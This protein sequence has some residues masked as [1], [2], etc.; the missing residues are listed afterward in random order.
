MNSFIGVV[1]AVILLLPNVCVSQETVA[2]RMTSAILSPAASAAETSAGSGFIGG[3]QGAAEAELLP[4]CAVIPAPPAMLQTKSKYRADS[5]SKSSIDDDA[6]AT[7]DKTVQPIRDSVR[8]LTNIAYADASG[9]LVSRMQAECVLRNVDRWA[10]ANALTDMRSVDAYLSRDRWVAE[11]A[12]AVQSARMRVGLSKGRMA[13]YSIWF[14]SLARD[15]VEAYSLG[16]GPKAKTNN[17][18]Y[19]AGLSVAAIGFLLDEPNLK[20]WGKRSFDIGACQVDNRGFLPAELARGD[21]ALDYHVY[22]LRPLAAIAKLATDNG[23]PLQSKCFEGFDHLVTMTRDAMRD[24]TEFERVAG[25][26]QSSTSSETEY[27]SAL[28]LDTLLHCCGI[29]KE[30]LR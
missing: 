27:S 25:V 7:R 22:A 30:T 6:L 20:A 4:H 10:A 16:V 1:V 11:I 5:K 21:R 19:W 12:L 14:G 3:A 15:T 26:R 23:E 29:L 17:H 28:K 13:L 2:V 8:A 18:R 24:A 9:S